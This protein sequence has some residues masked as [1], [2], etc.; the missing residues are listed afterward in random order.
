MKKT[1]GWGRGDE[2]EGTGCQLLRGMLFGMKEIEQRWWT[3]EGFRWGTSSEEHWSQNASSRTQRIQ[4]D[5]RKVTLLWAFSCKKSIEQRCERVI[6]FAR[7]KE[8]LVPLGEVV[9]EREHTFLWEQGNGWICRMWR[10]HLNYSD[11]GG[12]EEIR[13]E[14][15]RK[16][17]MYGGVLRRNVEAFWRLECMCALL[18]PSELIGWLGSN[19]EAVND[20]QMRSIEKQ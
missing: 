20:M 2:W 9:K 17:L 18:R 7:W 14:K 12:E 19:A 16:R 4:M 11:D 1:F 8:S 15:E 5:T 6:Q 10:G 3:I 13:H